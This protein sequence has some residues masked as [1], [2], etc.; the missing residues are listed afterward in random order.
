MTDSLIDRLGSKP[1]LSIKQCVSIGT[2]LN[3]DG[4][5]DGH[6][7]CSVKRPLDSRLVRS[8]IRPF[9]VSNSFAFQVSTDLKSSGFTVD[10]RV[11]HYVSVSMDH[12]VK[13]ESRVVEENT[14]QGVTTDDNAVHMMVKDGTKIRNVMGYAMKKMKVRIVEPQ[15]V[16]SSLRSSR[17]ARSP[18]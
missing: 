3:F 10:F 11:E 13:G 6:G 5:C 17:N 12:Y 8:R 14:P 2:M 16:L 4:D 1:I 15:K 9:H 7:D 18:T